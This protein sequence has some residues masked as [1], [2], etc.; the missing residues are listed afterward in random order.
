MIYQFKQGATYKGIDA[1]QAGEALE[2]IRISHKGELRPED[3]VKSAKAKGSPLH[4]AFTW[5]DSK[6]AS[7][8]RLQEARQL[9]RSVVL[10]EGK[11]CDLPAF[12]NVIVA[13]TNNQGEPEKRRYY[14]SAK[15]IAS[16]LEEYQS[17]L[18]IMQTELAT[19]QS[20]LSKLKALA[21]KREALKIEKATRHLESAKQALV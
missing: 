17:A 14:Q 3:V 12:W 20:S 9:I 15:V 8:F 1:Q 21:P 18:R 16:N 2:E 4:G 11:D 7:E 6:A 13:T 5:D 10:V 19:A